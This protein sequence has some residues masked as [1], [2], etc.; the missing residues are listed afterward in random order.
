MGEAMALLG[1]P[2]EALR[3]IHITGT[4]GKTSTAYFIRAMLEDAGLK[5][6]M[7]ISPHITSVNERVQVG[8]VPLAAEAFCAYTTACLTAL[9]PLRGRLTYFE[10]VIALALWVFVCESVDY[11]VVEVGIGGTRDAT[12]I[13]RRPDK[14]SVITPIGLDHTEKLGHTITEIAEQKAGIIVP[15]GVGVVA[16]QTPGALQ[17]IRS[18][19]DSIQASVQVIERADIPDYSNIPPFQ[20]NNWKLAASVVR[21]LAAR[22]GFELPDSIVCPT[23]DIFPETIAAAVPPARYEWIQV[24]THRVLLDGAHNPQ[25]VFCLVEAMKAQ[26]LGPM[27]ALATL[28]TAPDTKVSDTLA[29]LAPGVSFLVIPDFVLGHDGKVKKSV[30]ALDV[31]REAEKVGIETQI[32]P[33]LDQALHTLLSRPEPDLLVTGS[34]YLAAL[35][36]PLLKET[37]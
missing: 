17:V 18:R 21:G 20:W 19:A 32:V 12:N 5:T 35:V 29:A 24:G 11:A 36:R 13:L 2:H 16:D 30:P 3:V 28:S 4:S 15:G 6:G 25:K 9:E 1:N 31:A 26:G 10:T 23:P 8:G 33:D 37:A 27:P 34:L 7:T 22:D 14:V